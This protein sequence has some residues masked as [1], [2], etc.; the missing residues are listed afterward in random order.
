MV[1]VISTQGKSNTD[2]FEYPLILLLNNNIDETT[3]M[4]YYSSA[5]QRAVNDDKIKSYFITS[6][7]VSFIVPKLCHEIMSL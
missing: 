7:S 5:L 3:A 4:P 2:N 1:K 6:L